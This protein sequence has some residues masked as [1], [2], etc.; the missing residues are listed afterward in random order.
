[1]SILRFSL[2]GPAAVDS[3]ER[4]SYNEAVKAFLTGG[5][6]FIGSHLIDLLLARGAEVHVLVRNPDKESALLKREVNL[7]RGDLFSIPAL[8]AGLDIVFHLAG[9]TRSLNSADYYTVNQEGTASLFRSLARYKERPKVVVLSSQAAA[10]PSLDGHPV[11][12]SDPP[13]PVTDYGWSKLR[14]EQEALRFRDEFPVIIVRACSVFGPQD[15]DF[16]NY[17]KLMARG[18]ALSPRQEKTASLIYVKDLVEALLLCAGAEVPS[19]EIINIA[20]AR[21]YTWDEVVRVAAASLGRKCLTIKLPKGAFFLLS[22]LYEAGN[23]LTRNPGVFNRDKYRD[24]IQPGWLVDV[25]KAAELLSFRPRYSLQQAL[26][27]TISW[28]LAERWL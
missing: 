8:P 10:G 28:Y 25:G 17:F 27:E 23:H 21:P 1:M 9:K 7:L 4:L 20:D 18:I 15:R 22:I 13:R 5:T 26:Q 3:A 12:E 6:G 19:G 24:F 16:F 14:A 2:A 11:K